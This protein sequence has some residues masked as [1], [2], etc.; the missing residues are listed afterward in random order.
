MKRSRRD[1]DA[2]GLPPPSTY[3]QVSLIK[4]RNGRIAQVETLERPVF[5]G[6]SL[7]WSG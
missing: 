3:L 6:M 5:Y 4:I 1:R 2:R 7:G